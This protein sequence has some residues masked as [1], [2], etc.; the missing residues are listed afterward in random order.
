MSWLDWAS[1]YAPLFQQSAQ[2]LGVDPLDLTNII[3]YETGGTFNPWQAGPTTKWGQHRGFIQMG[4]PQRRQ[5]GYGPNNTPEQNMQAVER[6]FTASGLKP[7]MGLKD[8]YSIVN[9]GG[10]GRYNWS[11]RPGQTVATHV[12][13]MLGPHREKAAQFLGQSTGQ[14]PMQYAYDPLMQGQGFGPMLAGNYGGAAAGSNWGAANN[15]AL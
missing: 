14:Q 15:H 8:M 1:T 13:S 3:S 9:A 2:R 4:E 12:Q 5:F 11:D 7:G 10:P 6:Y